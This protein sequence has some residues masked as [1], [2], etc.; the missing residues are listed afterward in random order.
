MI[1]RPVTPKERG[2]IHRLLRTTGTFT[3]EEIRVAMELVDQVLKNPADPDYRIFIAMSSADCMVGFI[4]F[5]PIPF[6]DA[7]YDLYWIAVDHRFTKQGIGKR[8]VEFMESEIKSAG[9]RQIYVDTSS[10]PPYAVARL[11]YQKHGYDIVCTL[12][13]FY[14]TGD[15]KVIFRKTVHGQ[16]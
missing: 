6:T 8:L 7:G 16:M 3:R 2:P 11:F 1:I 4:C 15:H 12:Y 13:D 9:G 10:T 5:G 14:R